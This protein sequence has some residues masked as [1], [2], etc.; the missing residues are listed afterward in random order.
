MMQ[1]VKIG[2]V[3][4]GYGRSGIAGGVRAKSA[5]GVL[6]RVFWESL[7][8]FNREMMENLED[9]KHFSFHL[10]CNCL[11]SWFCAPH[12]SVIGKCNSMRNKTTHVVFKGHITIRIRWWAIFLSQIIILSSF[13][14]S[15][16]V[17]IVRSCFIILLLLLTY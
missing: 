8:D 14:P 10:H 2:W 16:A 11:S 1:H 7:I 12:P 13:P 9:R 4:H 15:L 3:K 17:W 5:I 6:R